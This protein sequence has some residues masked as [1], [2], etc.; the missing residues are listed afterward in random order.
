MQSCAEPR[1][2]LCVFFSILNDNQLSK[3]ITTLPVL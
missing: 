1:A 2:L 3:E